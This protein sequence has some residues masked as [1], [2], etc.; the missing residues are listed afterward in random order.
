MEFTLDDAGDEIVAN[1]LVTIPDGTAR[2][3]VMELLD[4]IGRGFPLSPKWRVVPD[5]L[6]PSD[7]VVE[8]SDRLVI[9]IR[10]YSDEDP[11]RMFSVVRIVDHT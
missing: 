10:L 5:L 1:W 6:V 4:D 3:R 8:V 11:K 9:V 2:A 7:R